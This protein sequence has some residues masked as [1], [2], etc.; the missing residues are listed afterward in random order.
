M[1]F[2]ILLILALLVGL[3]VR[4][5]Q[6]TTLPFPPNGDELFFGYY[7]WSLLHFGIDEYGTRFPFN[8]PSIGDYKYP[9]LAYLNMIGKTAV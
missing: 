5:Y 4:T 7:G 2:R 1:V 9:G 8:F 6:I 3:I